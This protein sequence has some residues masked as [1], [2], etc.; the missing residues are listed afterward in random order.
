MMY[1]FV[2][3]QNTPKSGISA[4]SVSL[5]VIGWEKKWKSNPL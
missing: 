5:Q 2:S 3:L 1:D 4:P